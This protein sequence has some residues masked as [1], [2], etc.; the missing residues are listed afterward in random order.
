MTPL[1]PGP[2]PHP[3]L[4]N[5]RLLMVDHISAQLA[6]LHAAHG[7]TVGLRMGPPAIGYRLTVTRDPAAI[8]YVLGA[9]SPFTKTGHQ[10]FEAFRD[11]LGTGLFSAYDEDWRWQRRVLQPLFTAKRSAAYA[12]LIRKRAD[13]AVSRWIA[14]GTP[15]SL[16]SEILRLTL[17]IVTDLLF[18]QG[19]DDVADRLERH[20]PTISRYVIERAFAPVPLPHTLPIPRIR[21]REAAVAEVYALVDEVLAEASADEESFVGRLREATD[22]ETGRRF[23]E[24]EIR[25]QV[26]VFIAAGHDTTATALTMALQLLGL[27]PDAQADAAAEV[28][29]EGP[30]ESADDAARL[31]WVTAV[32]DEAMRLYPSAPG[33]GRRATADTEVDGFHV[34]AGSNVYTNF[35]GLHRHPDLYPHPEAFR[36]QRFVEQ[37]SQSRPRHTFLPFGAGPRACIGAHTAV[38]EMQLILATVLSRATVVA[39]TRE[40]PVETA[41][42]LAPAVPLPARFLPR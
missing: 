4:G 24:A 33:T 22:P 27:H 30:V 41:I 11:I 37:P 16:R 23:T 7:D 12:G 34:P 28:D 38:L 14:A 6:D 8:G 9:S 35:W 26:L 31:S 19:R 10:F 17:V 3:L 2:A 42:T 39:T 13:E 5:I 20:F 40:M 21:A 29:R 25:D 36:P 15:L 1:A 18:G 32:I